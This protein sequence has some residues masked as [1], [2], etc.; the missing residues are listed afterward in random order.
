MVTAIIDRTSM[1]LLVYRHRRHFTPWSRLSQL[2]SPGK[3]SLLSSRCVVV[4]FCYNRS[5]VKEVVEV[6][7]QGV[8]GRHSAER[9]RCQ[10]KERGFAAAHESVLDNN[11]WEREKRTPQIRYDSGSYTWAEPPRE[12]RDGP[13]VHRMQTLPRVPSLETSAPNLFKKVL[14]LIVTNLTESCLIWW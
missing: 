9:S 3:N 7:R 6:I 13:Y 1:S 14:W 11:N 5:W 8:N 10:E 2:I 4:L 12:Y